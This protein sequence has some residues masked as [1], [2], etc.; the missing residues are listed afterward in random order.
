[1]ALADIYYIIFRHKR[2]I[3]GLAGI[4][5]ITAILVFALWPKEYQS[6]AKLYISYVL[7]NKS[8]R[9]IGS[10]TTIQMAGAG[11]YNL[12]N[13]ELEII[14]SYDLAAEVASNVGPKEILG[15]ATGTNDVSNL[16]KATAA[17]RLHLKVGAPGRSDCIQISF[18]YP[19]PAVPQ[20]VLRQV[21]QCYLKKHAEIHHP[22]GEND[23]FLQ[24]EID[25]WRRSLNGI[26]DE[27]RKKL[28]DANII[29][30]EDS[31]QDYAGQAAK[32]HQ[33]IDEA[34][35][36]LEEHKATISE[37]SRLL[38]A[39]AAPASVMTHAGATNLATSNLAT[40]NLA[41]SSAVLTRVADTNVIANNAT[42]SNSLAGSAV[43]AG[44]VPP[45]KLAEYQRLRSVLE[46][47]RRREDDLKF[48][49]TGEN[50]LVQAVEEQIADTQKLITKMEVENPGLVSIKTSQ[51]AQSTSSPAIIADPDSALRTR[52]QSELVE[53][54][55]TQAKINRLT[56]ILN[57]VQNDM[58]NLLAMEGPISELERRRTIAE[59]NYQN[60][61]I[62]LEQSRTDELLGPDKINRINN[63]EQP[64]PPAIKHSKA[65]ATSA[66]IFLACVCAAFGL[67][68]AWE[69]YF[70]HALKHPKEIE[71]KLGKPFLLS[72]PWMNG[73]GES[74]GLEGSKIAGLLADSGASAQ[75]GSLQAVVPAAETAAVAQGD[76][77]LQPFYE[78]LRD[79]L[80]SYFEALNLTHKPKLVAVCGCH[81]AAGVTTIATGLAASLS[82]T[83]DG[84]V[85]LVDMNQQ[86]GHAHHFYNGQ[87]RCG[88]DEVLQ[89]GKHDE[90]MVQDNLYVV[91]ETTLNEKLP[92]MLPKR[93]SHLLPQMKASDYDYIIFDMPPVSQISVTP[94]LARFMDMVLVVIESEKTDRDVAARTLAWLSESKTNIGLVLNK[95]RSY[96]PERILPEL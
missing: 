22:L 73:N 94:R 90:A 28:A 84:S 79:R 40:S 37:L 20:A 61:S 65:V 35:V 68:F 92:R 76:F 49:F 81:G 26:D 14:T 95:R 45:D 78:T 38:A 19:N 96:V 82:E 27:L 23:E 25:E 9:Q 32:L 6:E 62:S 10:D 5:L 29:S 64:T 36:E 51:I 83:G 89:K 2:L 75:A 8:P 71:A 69:L 4:G 7:E 60:S 34:N 55:R 67:A 53:A 13:N 52:L 33:D 17:V 41:A 48:Q 59:N 72:I 46:G 31:K 11:G 54:I 80:V 86:D 74:H 18:D 39:K 16:A 43:T 88:L 50:K 58:T 56:N 12:I 93:F 91:R 15:K 42:S 47:Q 57:Q 66:G 44:E 3:C 1:L 24:K 87:L 70:D 63:F 85:L 21:I 30:L 77:R